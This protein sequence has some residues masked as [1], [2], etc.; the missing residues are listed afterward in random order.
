MS[1]QAGLFERHS[2]TSLKILKAQFVGSAPFSQDVFGGFTHARILTYSADLHMITKLAEQFD[3]MEC[4]FGYEGVVG[5]VV[6]VIAFQKYVADA[7]QVVFRDLA[8]AQK[9]RAMRQIEAG[10][11]KLLVVREAVSHSKIYLLE[12]SQ[13]KRILV[14]S[15]NFSNQAFSGRQHETLLQFDDD[16]RAWDFFS[17]QYDEVKSRSTSDLP[18]KALL[19]DREVKIEQVPLILDVQA[20]T[21]GIEVL[22]NIETSTTITVPRVIHHVEKIGEPVRKFIAAAVKPKQGKVILTR[23]V[24]G[25]FVSLVRSQRTEEDTSE[26]TWLSINSQNRS[27]VL[28]GEVFSLECTQENIRTDVSAMIEYFENYNQGFYGDIARQQRDYFAFMSWFYFSPFICDLRNMAVA[29]QSYIFDLPFFAIIYGKSNCGKTKLIETLMMSMFGR[30]RFVSKEFFTRSGMRSLLQTSKRFPVVFDDVDKRKFSDHAPDIIKDETLLAEEYP[31]FVLS[32]NADDHAFPTEIVKRCLMFYTQASLPG[33]NER[34][35]DLHN[36]I[37]SIRK[38]LTG[39]LYR[40]YLKRTLGRLQDG[41]PDDILRFSSEILVGIMQEFSS[42]PLPGWCKPMTMSQ[43]KEKGFDKIRDELRNLYLNNKA[44]WKV[45]SQEV[46]LE[47]KGFES[48]GLMKDI[49]DWILRPGSKAGIIVM[50]RKP[51]EDFLHMRFKPDW[52]RFLLRSRP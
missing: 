17:Q 52:Q 44:A 36:S 41:S 50:A 8:G 26:A 7:A 22:V 5:S 23:K 45:K 18:T 49:P 15:A 20:S 31:S 11:L 1:Y 2:F 25:E 3:S 39:D 21:A 34:A 24:I 13:Q 6:D 40:E 32:M 10:K 30:Y 33:N 9:Q 46:V 48:A 43:Y 4:I 38:R 28:S 37:S 47:V 35:K 14:G 29:T 42:K 51:L 12:N 27:V 16:E 19:E